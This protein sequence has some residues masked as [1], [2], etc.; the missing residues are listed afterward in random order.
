M[1]GL[2]NLRRAISCSKTAQ[3]GLDFSIEFHP[4]LL[5]PTL[6]EQPVCKR[7][8]YENKFGKDRCEVVMRSLAE[9]GKKSGIDL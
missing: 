8:R 9:R 2:Q 5:D 4:F 6:T 3:L 1:L 7:T